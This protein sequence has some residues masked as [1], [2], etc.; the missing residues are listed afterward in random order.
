VSKKILRK[1]LLAYRK[2]NYKVASL[3]YTLLKDI[4]KKFNLLRNK[5]I[6]AYFPINYEIDC[7]EI[8]KK[9]EKSGN[10][11]SLPITEKKNK[12]DFFEW[13]FNKP[14]LIGKIGIPEPCTK[15]K[16]Y[17]D[18]LLVPLVAFDKYKFRLGYGG[19]YYDRYIQKIKKIKK[20]L[21][22]GISFS[23]QEVE[24][25]PKNKHDQKLDFILTENYIKK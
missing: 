14:L 21:T 20:I 5:I 12:M 13:S 9:L 1:K 19:G 6:G 4:L 2:N 16:V 15:K 24:K 25:I 7:L 11:I 8:L 23:F 10:K 17:P 3:K 22:I 18:V